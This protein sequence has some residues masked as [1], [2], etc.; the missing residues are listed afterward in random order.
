V[1]AASSTCANGIQLTFKMRAKVQL[2]TLQYDTTARPNGDKLALRARVGYARLAANC[3]DFKKFMASK[4]LFGRFPQKISS[5]IL[6]STLFPLIT[7][8]L[9]CLFSAILPCLLALSIFSAAFLKVHKNMHLL[10]PELWLMVV[11][12]LSGWPTHVQC[13]ESV[14]RSSHI[15]KSHS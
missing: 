3:D 8:F 11:Y 14:C 2:T 13:S 12:I 4:G 9:C 15:I 6:K 10:Q 1:T 7:G 5:E